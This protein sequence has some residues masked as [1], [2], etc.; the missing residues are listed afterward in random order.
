[1]LFLHP[2]FHLSSYILLRNP[3]ERLRSNK[4]LNRTIPCEPVGDFVSSHS[5]MSGDSIQPH[6]MPG[7]VAVPEVHYDPSK[8]LEALSQRALHP[9]R[10]VSLAAAAPLWRLQILHWFGGGAILGCMSMSIYKGSGP[11]GPNTPRPQSRPFVPHVRSREPWSFTEAPDGPQ[12]Y[13]LNVL[14][15]QEKGA[16]ICMSEWGQSFTFAKNMGWGFLHHPTFPT[17]WTD[18]QS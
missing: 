3:Q 18:Q 4:P 1:M 17:Q 5:S 11:H 14:R 16:Q 10:L 15:L 9:R 8:C 12:A 6:S 13:T 2:A 7:R